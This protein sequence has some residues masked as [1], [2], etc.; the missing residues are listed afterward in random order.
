[1]TSEPILPAAA[2]YEPSMVLRVDPAGDV[3]CLVRDPE[4]HALCHPTN[5][6]FRGSTLFLAN[7]G[8]WHVSAVEVGVEGSPLPPSR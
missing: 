7:L 2:C 8:R 6:A 4:A 1:V 3:R 5:L